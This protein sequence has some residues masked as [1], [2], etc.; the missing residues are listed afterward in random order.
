ME[1]NK[2]FSWEIKIL[3]W[4]IKIT[5]FIYQILRHHTNKINKESLVVVFLHHWIKTEIQNKS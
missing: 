1:A 4:I 2:L 5:N 3:L